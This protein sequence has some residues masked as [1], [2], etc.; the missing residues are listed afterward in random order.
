MGVFFMISG[1]KLRDLIH[2]QVVIIKSG[3]PC[4]FKVSHSN[5]SDSLFSRFGAM[6]DLNTITC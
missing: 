4:T 2:R 5:A 1:I 6:R 3:A